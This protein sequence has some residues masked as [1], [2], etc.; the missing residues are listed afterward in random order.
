MDIRQVW[1]E[2]EN[3]W[4]IALSGEI[5]IYN[6]P[7]LKENILEILEQNKGNIVIDCIDLKYIIMLY[8]IYI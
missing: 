2:K 3:S 5:D 1:Y 6:A 4:F 8:N 7:Q